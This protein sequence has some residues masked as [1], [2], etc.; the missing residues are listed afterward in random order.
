MEGEPVLLEF[1]VPH[2]LLA[3]PIAYTS[4]YKVVATK[5]AP[6][7]VVPIAKACGRYVDWYRSAGSA[8]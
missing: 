7:R 8:R 4:I 1:T 5:V 6:E 2:P 3:L